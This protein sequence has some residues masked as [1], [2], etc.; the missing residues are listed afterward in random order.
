MTSD[1]TNNKLTTNGMIMGFTH[2]MKHIS[3]YMYMYELEHEIL[4]VSLNVHADVSSRARG[5]N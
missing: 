5:L 1:N 2:E 3:I 4:I